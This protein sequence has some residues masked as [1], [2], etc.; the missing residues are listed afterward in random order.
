MEIA[1]SALLKARKPDR[2]K[3]DEAMFEEYVRQKARLFA[4]AQPIMVG[5]YDKNGILTF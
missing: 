4:E 3:Y 5:L 1:R 2:Y